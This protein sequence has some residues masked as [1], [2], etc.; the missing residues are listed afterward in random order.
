MTTV[1]SALPFSMVDEKAVNNSIGFVDYEDMPTNMFELVVSLMDSVGGVG[2]I[3]MDD[4]KLL[5]TWD[6]PRSGDVDGL[7]VIY[8]SHLLQVG[9]LNSPRQI[10]ATTAYAG[11]GVTLASAL[12]A[13]SRLNPYVAMRDSAILADAMPYSYD[14]WLAHGIVLMDSDMV[15]LATFVLEKSLTMGSSHILANRCLAVCYLHDNNPE[16]AVKA[17]EEMM[18]GKLA[19][20]LL[21]DNA[22]RAAYG[23]ALLAMKRK[24]EAGVQFMAAFGFSR[25]KM[26]VKQWMEWGYRLDLPTLTEA[27]MEPKAFAPE[28]RR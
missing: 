7:R 28:K 12:V 17:A 2:I 1:V 25:V 22:E 5:A 16:K 4:E 11:L 3:E 23:F 13:F 10:I 20:G 24:L 19:D 9:A 15:R 6:P 18:R 8:L 27:V 14:V 26:T 21:P